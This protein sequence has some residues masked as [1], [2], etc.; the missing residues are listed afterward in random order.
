MEPEF[1]KCLKEIQTRV[2]TAYQNFL[3]PDTKFIL[4]LKY[5]FHFNFLGT[6]GEV[7][8][9]KKVILKENY[10]IYFY[11]CVVLGDVMIYLSCGRWKSLYC[12]TS[13][14]SFLT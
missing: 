13:L 10:M 2:K 12:V 7:V 4:W 8:E 3:F 6:A 5:L 1:S 11:R 14:L 9:S